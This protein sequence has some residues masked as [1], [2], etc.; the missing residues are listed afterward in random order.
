[1]EEIVKLAQTFPQER[2]HVVE[3]VMKE[4]LEVLRLFPQES[5][6]ERIVQ[7]GKVIPQKRL[8]L[9]GWWSRAWLITFLKGCR[10]L[11]MPFFRDDF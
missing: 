8:F 9:S 7:V 4:T 5:F 2:P 11:W 3:R 1:M 10:R 6:Q